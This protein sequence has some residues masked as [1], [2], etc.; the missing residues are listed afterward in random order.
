MTAVRCRTLLKQSIWKIPLSQNDLFLTKHQTDLRNGSLYCIL[1]TLPS[2]HPENTLLSQEM[3]LMM[4]PHFHRLHCENGH[5]GAQTE[6]SKNWVALTCWF[7]HNFM[8]PYLLSGFCLSSF[9][10]SSWIISL[11]ELAAKSQAMLH[12]PC[13]VIMATL[14]PSM[15]HF[16]FC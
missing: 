5:P 13:Q 6:K 14:S 7:F 10:V 4:V 9:W 15:S 12:T 11:R 16:G 2:I 1:F 3:T 8:A